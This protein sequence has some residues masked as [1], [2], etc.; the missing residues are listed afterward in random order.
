M[1]FSLEKGLRRLTSLITAWEMIRRQCPV[2]G[3][4]WTVVFI[5]FLKIQ[6]YIA[7]PFLLGES[8]LLHFCRLIIFKLIAKFRSRWKFIVFI[9]GGDYVVSNIPISIWGDI[10]LRFYSAIVWAEYGGRSRIRGA[11]PPKNRA[12]MTNQS[13]IAT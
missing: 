2:Q 7:N 8:N 12:F 4:L 11:K 9:N 5:P 6:S 13:M 1:T 3:V 10:K